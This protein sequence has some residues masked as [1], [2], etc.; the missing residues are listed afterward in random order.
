MDTVTASDGEPIGTMGVWKDSFSKRLLV[1]VTLPIFYALNRPSMQ[2]F[3][4]A[5]YDFALRCNGFAI[6]HKGR[7]GLTM[8]EENFLRRYLKDV[9]SGVFFDV[10]ANHGSYSLYLRHLVPGARI[11]AFEPHP[12]SFAILTQEVPK[13]GTVLVNLALSDKPGEMTLYDFAEDDGSTQ[14]SLSRDAVALFS[15]DVVEHR[16]TCTTLD[17][18]MAG[19]AI[20]RID[21]LKVD[22]E[23]FDLSVLHGAKQALDARRIGTIQ[24]EFIPA[25]IITKTRI[26]DFMTLLAGYHL[27]RV[28]LNG[29]LIA[30]APYDVK[31]CEIYVMQNL[32][33]IAKDDR[34]APH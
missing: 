8:G 11:Y 34:R 4:R 30:L 16:V 7:H 31:R 25:N 22:T 6:N 5:I 26:R 32:I 21:F 3:G 12:K 17:A 33:A 27:F 13:D 9:K 14:A 19:N 15:G 18:Y 1:G 29:E 10:G 24:F 28:C 20:E 2:W 23:G